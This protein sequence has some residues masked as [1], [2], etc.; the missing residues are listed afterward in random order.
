MD[1]IHLSGSGRRV[2]GVRPSRAGDH[3]A[4]E[5]ASGR[6][7][8]PRGP[9]PGADELSTLVLLRMAENASDAVFLADRRAGVLT[10]VSAGIST[11]LGARPDQVTAAPLGELVHPEDAERWTSALNGCQEGDPVRVRVRLR[12]TDLGWNWVELRLTRLPRDSDADGIVG[13]LRDINDEVSAIEELRRRAGTDQLTGLIARGEGLGR[14]ERH[15][16]HPP[17]TGSALAVAYLDVDGLK[18]ANDQFGHAV[19]DELLYVTGL[20]ISAC[21][22]ADDLVIRLG[23]D[24]LL[25]VLPGVHVLED[26][27]SLAEQIR[28]ATSLP[29]TVD[30][31]PAAVTV[32]IG[33]TLA[34]PSD[35]VDSVVKRAHAAMYEAKRA[36]GNRVRV[37]R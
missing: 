28:A 2:D 26:A 7:P 30:G 12:R 33:V 8:S 5:R 25:I 24:E 34:G 27:E 14:L 22:R 4:V 23:G 9:G 29:I 32:S 19:G 17:R 10:W 11:V 20:R 31:Q 35:D 6:V 1:R 13:A 37:R 18:A 36:G 15:L 3:A 16:G 21:V